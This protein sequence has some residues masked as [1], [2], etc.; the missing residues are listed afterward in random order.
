MHDYFEILKKQQDIIKKT[1]YKCDLCK[2]E[3]FIYK[4]GFWYDCECMKK[5]R[6]NEYLTGRGVPYR[7]VDILDP[8]VFLEKLNDNDNAIVNKVAVDIFSELPNCNFYCFTANDR[9]TLMLLGSFLVGLSYSFRKEHKKARLIN[10]ELLYKAFMR[11]DNEVALEL[12]K[13]YLIVLEFGDESVNSA[14]STVLMEFYKYRFSLPGVTVFL[15]SKYTQI[16]DRYGDDVEGLFN[17]RIVGFNI[18]SKIN[19]LV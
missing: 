11:E 3:R 13:E 16:K 4:Q 2:D 10:M 7:F 1:S 9:E 12:L 14:T 17:D 19:Y 18:S 15:N 5:I 8:I 6:R